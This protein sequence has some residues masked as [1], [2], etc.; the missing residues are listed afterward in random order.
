MLTVCSR[1]PQWQKNPSVIIALRHSDHLR[2]LK[3]HKCVT[4]TWSPFLSIAKIAWLKLAV[5]VA[6]QTICTAYELYWK[7]VYPEQTSDYTEGLKT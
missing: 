6:D 5:A 7:Q 2:H 1:V 4:L 3:D